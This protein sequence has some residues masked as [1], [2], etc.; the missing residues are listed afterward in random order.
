MGH[1][2]LTP[3]SAVILVNTNLCGYGVDG[4]PRRCFAHGT[5][6]AIEKKRLQAENVLA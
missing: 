2:P 5:V 3:N 1:M 6:Y 4:I